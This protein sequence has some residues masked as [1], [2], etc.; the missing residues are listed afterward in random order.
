MAVGDVLDICCS[1]T[2]FLGDVRGGDVVWMGVGVIVGLKRCVA[3][4]P[5]GLE[6]EDVTL[7][8]KDRAE[9]WVSGQQPMSE[10]FPMGCILASDQCR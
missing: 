7:A 8:G 3:R 6:M 1:G 9:D 5:M 2:Q 4:G 10:C